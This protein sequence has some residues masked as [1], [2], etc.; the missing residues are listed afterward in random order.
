MAPDFPNQRRREEAMFEYHGWITLRDS[1]SEEGENEVISNLSVVLSLIKETLLQ[2]ELGN[3]LVDMRPVNGNHYI[4]LNAFQNHEA[5]L[6]ERLL[7]FYRYVAEE[8]VGS[9]G[10]LYIHDDEDT[11]GADN[12]FHVYVLAKGRIEKK[13]DTFLSPC[14]PTIEE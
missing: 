9:Y 4:A 2:S 7:Q 1:F 11:G 12:E 3:G 13:R 8:A 14:I 5:G 10:L 6:T